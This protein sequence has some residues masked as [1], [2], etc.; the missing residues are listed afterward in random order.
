[1]ERR[2]VQEYKKR[3]PKALTSRNSDQQ[4]DQMGV[5]LTGT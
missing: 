4:R 5:D 1:M 3:Y 2:L